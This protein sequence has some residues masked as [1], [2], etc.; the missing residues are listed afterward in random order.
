MC[1]NWKLLSGCHGNQSARSPRSSFNGKLA[2]LFSLFCHHICPLLLRLLMGSERAP[3]DPSIPLHQREQAI[4][5]LAN[6][7]WRQSGLLSVGLTL[8]LSALASDNTSVSL[9]GAVSAG[10]LW[11]LQ[12]QAGPA[13]PRALPQPAVRQRRRRARRSARH[14]QLRVHQ[15]PG[16][17][18]P[19][20]SGDESP[21]LCLERLTRCKHTELYEDKRPLEKG[22][23]LMKTNDI[24]QNIWPSVSIQDKW[25]MNYTVK[26]QKGPKTPLKHLENVHYFSSVYNI[27]LNCCNKT[28]THIKSYTY[29]L[30]LCIYFQK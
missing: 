2:P 7:A 29:I 1:L 19:L 27:L 24:R 5:I 25:M 18:M 12:L 6:V 14:S 8:F 15:L 28:K 16:W 23:L 13:E 21:P 26:L 11:L 20:T 22:L 9:S 10:V 30:R 3:N 4:G 17:V